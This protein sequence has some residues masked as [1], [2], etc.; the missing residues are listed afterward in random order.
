MENNGKQQSCTAWGR[1]WRGIRLQ[2]LSRRA[3][4]KIQNL[5]YFGPYNC[6]VNLPQ[7]IERNCTETCVKVP[8]FIDFQTQNGG[9]APRLEDL[10][11]AS[12]AGGDGR[13][14]LA[15]AFQ[16]APASAFRTRP[17]PSS[18]RIAGREVARSSRGRLF[19]ENGGEQNN[20][21]NNG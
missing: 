14:P 19:R 13:D 3:T 4:P 10:A 15:P 5:D 2:L 18:T 12:S 21:L 6:R 7:S 16:R 20:A 9:P 11:L 1:I 8:N 17:R